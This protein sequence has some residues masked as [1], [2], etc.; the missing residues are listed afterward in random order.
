MYEVMAGVTKSLG[1]LLLGRGEAMADQ[2]IV[3]G[4]RLIIRAGTLDTLVDHKYIPHVARE[5]YSFGYCLKRTQL[6]MSLASLLVQQLMNQ[7]MTEFPH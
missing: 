4:L 6:E 7:E 1:M 5:L 2:R 3:N